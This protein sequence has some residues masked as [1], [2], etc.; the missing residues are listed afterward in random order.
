[1][2][3]MQPVTLLNLGL[4]LLLL[5]LGILLSLVYYTTLLW[6][7]WAL[8][9]EPS[10][11]HLLLPGGLDNY[12]GLHSLIFSLGKQNGDANQVGFQIHLIGGLTAA[13]PRRLRKAQ[14]RL[15]PGLHPSRTSST[16]STGYTCRLRSTSLAAHS[17]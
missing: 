14:P 17:R 6:N 10:L 15:S 1:M 11:C 8:S 12:P 13:D 7:H 16:S 9:R 2:S 4:L 5:V 3:D